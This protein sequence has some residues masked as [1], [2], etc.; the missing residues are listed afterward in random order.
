MFLCLL[1]FA[2]ALK[3]PN[4]LKTNQILIFVDNDSELLSSVK[5]GLNLECNYAIDLVF[6]A[7]AAVEKMIQNEFVDAI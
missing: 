3:V 2:I 7:D 6:S 5:K 1:S 4:L